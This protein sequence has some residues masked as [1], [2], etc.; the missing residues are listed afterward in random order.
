MYFL[1]FKI[2]RRNTNNKVENVSVLGNP[3][4]L[5]HYGMLKM[6]W[7]AINPPTHGG[8]KSWLGQKVP[9]FLIILGPSL[10]WLKC[11]WYAYKWEIFILQNNFHCFVELLGILCL[12]D[13]AFVTHLF[14][15]YK[16]SIGLIKN[17]ALSWILKIFTKI[18][19]LDKE[20]SLFC[21][22]M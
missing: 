18:T 6:T 1:W 5:Q 13:D 17:A 14:A 22:K 10:D 12:V 21:N 8:F 15:N 16:D 3:A 20:R 2:L 4:G 11:E 7:R 9:K 19:N